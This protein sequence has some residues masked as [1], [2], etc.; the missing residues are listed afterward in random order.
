MKKTL[1]FLIPMLTRLTR[2]SFY[3]KACCAHDSLQIQEFEEFE[4]KIHEFESL[5]IIRP[6][7]NP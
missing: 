1:F 7:I 5:P 3:C 4:A 2:R 6:S